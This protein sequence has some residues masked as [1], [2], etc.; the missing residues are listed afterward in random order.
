MWGYWEEKRKEPPS[1][2][3]S[4]KDRKA[5]EKLFGR[6]DGGTPPWGW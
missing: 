2:V 6:F 4:K 5:I 3:M 1:V